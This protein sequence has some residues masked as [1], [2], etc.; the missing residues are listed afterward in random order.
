MPAI[1]RT[2]RVA[3]LPRRDANDP[4]PHVEAPDRE[5]GYTAGPP[6]LRFYKLGGWDSNPQPFG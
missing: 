1:D 2:Y 5:F 6:S 3:A 4:A